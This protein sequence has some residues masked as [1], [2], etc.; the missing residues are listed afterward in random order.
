M[1]HSNLA[2]AAAGALALAGLAAAD[3]VERRGAESALEGDVRID[4]SGVTVRTESGAEHHVTWDRVRGIHSDDPLLVRSRYMETAVDLWRARSRVER[5]D[6]TLAEP[7]LERLFEQYRGRTDATARVVAEG[8]LRCRLARGANALA[9]IPA[10]ETARLERAGIAIESYG[11]L[12]AAIDPETALCPR[13]APAWLRSRTLARVERDLAA[14]DARGDVVV[15]TI[16]R[17]YRRGVRQHLAGAPETQPQTV[18]AAPDAEP[19]TVTAATD[20]AV[21]ADHR[22]AGF[23]AILVDCGSADAAVR[24]GARDRAAKQLGTAPRWAIGWA[25]F[26]IGDSLL[27]ESG[28]GRRQR[29]IVELLHLPAEHRGSLPFLAGLALSRAAAASRADGDAATA[30]VLTDELTRSFPNHPVRL[31]AE[32]ATIPPA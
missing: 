3:V 22:G 11:S 4:L 2:V 14:Y 28:I 12:D 20:A 15:D 6:T 30:D 8:L 5:G 9:I 31:P 21:V 1:R 25:R 17:L 19:Q 32:A 18:T 27:L 26:A 16:A 29:G 23:L 13:L 7:L 10:L 24:A